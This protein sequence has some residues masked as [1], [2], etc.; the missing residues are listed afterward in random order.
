MNNSVR[1][2]N[3]RSFILDI[4]T[5]SHLSSPI[6]E[7]STSIR[8]NFLIP[9]ANNK[10]EYSSKAP[11]RSNSL[12]PDDFEQEIEPEKLT[13][14]MKYL[15]YINAQHGYGKVKAILSNI[16]TLHTNESLPITR[17]KHETDLLQDIR[18]K[19]ESIIFRNRS[20]EITKF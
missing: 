9:Q 10:F 1:K 19:H 6:D 17:K 12:Y 2:D 15:P 16:K 13:F 3:I 8:K 18:A 11:S 4:P 14:Y 7:S 20:V 5:Q